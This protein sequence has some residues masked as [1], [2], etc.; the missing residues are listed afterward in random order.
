MKKAFG[1]IALGAMLFLSA[2]GGKKADMDD[3]K[4]VA[5][6]SCDKMKE[7]TALM[8]ATPPDEKKIIAISEEMETFL[9]ELEAHHGDK[10]SE[11][12]A[13][14]QTET[15]SICPELNPS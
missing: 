14:V 12:E 7:I 10:Y 11:F 6:Y 13:K 3:P 2:C 1:A 8:E 9:K 5:K 15:N 4:S